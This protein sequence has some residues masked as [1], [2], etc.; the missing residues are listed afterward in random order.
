MEVRFIGDLTPKQE[1]F[2]IALATSDSIEEASSEVGI[3]RNTAYNYLKDKTFA[4]AKKRLRRNTMDVVSGRLQHE[5]MESINVL[6]EI[7]DDP[8]VSPHTRL[9]ASKELLDK[10]YKSYEID[11]ILERVEILEEALDE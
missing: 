8:D 2:L 4:E 9:Q 11:D 6:K 7:R 3:H 10:A 5:A 1:K